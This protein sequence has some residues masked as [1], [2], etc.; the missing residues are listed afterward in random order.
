MNKLVS[1]CPSASIAGTLVQ[2]WHFCNN[3]Q[4]ILVILNPE[5]FFFSSQLVLEFCFG[6][7]LFVWG[8]LIVFWLT[9]SN[10]YD[11]SSSK[12]IL[13]CH[14]DELNGSIIKFERW[15]NSNISFRSIYQI[16]MDVCWLTSKQ[17]INLPWAD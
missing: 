1:F 2:I 9:F 15:L 8:Y 6:G 14:F 4:I 17:H 5:I 13:I 3:L 7:F 11:V 10:G 16:V 12:R